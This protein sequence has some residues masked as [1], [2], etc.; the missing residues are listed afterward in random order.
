ML[1]DMSPML[2]SLVAA[3]L[4]DVELV[5]APP[6]VTLA[7]AVSDGGVDVLLTRVGTVARCETALGDI[8]RIAPLGIVAIDRRGHWGTAYRLDS[9]P[10]AASADGR[11][12][13]AGAIALAAGQSARALH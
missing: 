7:Q 8:A 11:L 1:G 6:D 2:S 5:A 4:G 9:Q 12:D 13:L 3:Q 10:V